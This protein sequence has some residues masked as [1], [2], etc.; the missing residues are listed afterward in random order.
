LVLNTATS[1]ITVILEAESLAPVLH[2]EPG[3]S[4][5]K[6]TLQPGNYTLVFRARNARGTLYSIREQ[7]TITSGNTTNLKLHG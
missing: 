1:G 4:N 6:H 7:F 2:L 5:G 3:R